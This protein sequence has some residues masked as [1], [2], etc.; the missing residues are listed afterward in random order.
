MEELK[1]LLERL[2]SGSEN[3]L[4]EIKRLLRENPPKYTESKFYG[5]S[6]VCK[7]CKQ[8]RDS[9]GDLYVGSIVEVRVVGIPVHRSLIYYCKRSE[10]FI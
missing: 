4:E 3:V 1:H 9:C 6:S 10:P 5:F 2:E 8:R 7:D